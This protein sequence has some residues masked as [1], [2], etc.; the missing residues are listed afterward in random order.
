MSDSEDDGSAIVPKRQKVI[1]HGTLEEHM[2][3]HGKEADSLIQAGISAG[4]IN[5]SDGEFNRIE[6]AVPL[7]IIYVILKSSR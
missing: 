3:K 5:I 6:I 4:N 1:H 7:T 2:K